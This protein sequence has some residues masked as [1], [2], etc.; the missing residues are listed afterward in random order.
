MTNNLKIEQIGYYKIIM[1]PPKII[2][3]YGEKARLRP[4]FKWDN[5]G[6]IL[7]L[8][9]LWGPQAIQNRYTP[10]KY[11]TGDTLDEHERNHFNDYKMILQER[12]PP[13]TTRG[14]DYQDFMKHTTDLVTKCTDFHTDNFVHQPNDP[15]WDECDLIFKKWQLP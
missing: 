7:H 1:H 9:P 12:Q 5:N 8:H 4:D 6:G 15:L 10:P 14:K 3:S 11:G 2:K 13:M